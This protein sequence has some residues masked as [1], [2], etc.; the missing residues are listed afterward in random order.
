MDY[1]SKRGTFG[2]TIWIIE[3]CK[4]QGGYEYIYIYHHN[5]HNFLSL[6]YK[7]HS[8]YYMLPSRHTSYLADTLEK[9][10]QKQTKTQ[11]RN[12]MSSV[13]PT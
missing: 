2:L 7:V 4:T 13:C 11:G 12:R 6:S 9:R 10:K 3:L 1:I 5:S 8:T